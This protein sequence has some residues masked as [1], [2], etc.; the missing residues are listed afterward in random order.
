LQA[1]LIGADS[2]LKTDQYIGEF[3]HGIAPK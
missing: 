1:V 3:F 2:L